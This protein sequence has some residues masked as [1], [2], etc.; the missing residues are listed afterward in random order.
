MMLYFSSSYFKTLIF[1]TVVFLSGTVE[2]FAEGHV[3]AR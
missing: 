2:D 3:F 1:S